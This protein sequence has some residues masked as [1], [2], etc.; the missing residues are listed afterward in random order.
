MQKLSKI[1]Y[2]IKRYGII[3]TLKKIM[4][5]LFKLNKKTE[6]HQKELYQKWILQNEPNQENLEKQKK[7]KFRYQPKISIV[8]PMYNTDERF[9]LELFNSVLAQT[10]KNWELCLAD[11]SDEQNETILAMCS[12]CS[13]VKYKFLGKNKGISENTNQALEMASGDFFAFLDHDDCLPPFSLYEIVKIINENPE[14]EFIY[15]DEDKIDENGERF[16]PH[17]KP[18]FSPETLACHNYITHLVVIKKELVDK[19]GKLNSEFDGA[20]DFD[21]VLR[22]TENTKN[23]LHIPKILYH[24]RAHQNSTA[25]EADTKNYAYEAGVKVIAEHLQRMGKEGIV[26]NPREVLGMYQIKYAVKGRP[27][28]SI[29]I[30]NKGDYKELKKCLKSILELTSYENYE[31]LILENNSE[32]KENFTYYEKIKQNPKIRVIEFKEKEFNYAKM[33][34]FGVE[35]ADG[36][37]ILQIDGDLKLLTPDWLEIF[38]GYAQNKEIGAVGARLYDSKMR[39][40]NAG[41]ASTAGNLLENLPFGQHGYFG[42]E[43]L[44]SNVSAVSGDCLFARREIYEEIGFMDEKLF[45]KSFCDVDFCLKILEKGY[46]V[47]YNPYVELIQM[48]LKM[49]DNTKNSEK[50]ERLEREKKYFQNKWK[51]TLEKGDS[52]YNPNFSR[53]NGN[54]EIKIER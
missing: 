36:D 49:C 35:N 2:N 7:E 3:R 21:F 34:H 33:I 39:L 16:E 43:A 8:V 51:E 20:Q 19:I 44:T 9:F 31:I 11:G 42:R 47:V 52:Y 5:K 1:I 17:F 38:M 41:I 23:I 53:K 4:R 12:R 27:K 25:N 26:K 54:F 28:V 50:Q 24:W 45:Q 6:K 10:Y 40:K 14:V 30:L 18:D 15:S 48:K 13:K 22:A 46:R 32:E 29:L 37:F